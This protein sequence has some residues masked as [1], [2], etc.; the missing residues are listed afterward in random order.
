MSYAPY[1]IGFLSD[2]V[3]S[4][5]IEAADQL[6]FARLVLRSA[7]PRIG[8]VAVIVLLKTWMTPF[9]LGCCL[10]KRSTAVLASN[11]PSITPACSEES[12]SPLFEG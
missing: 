10:D 3:Q 4:R 12:Q 6:S 2:S 8:T 11:A 9:E 7:H 5:P 1:S